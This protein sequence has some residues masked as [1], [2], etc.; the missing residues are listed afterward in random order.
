MK[1]IRIA[2]LLLIVSIPLGAT[3][4]AGEIFSFSPGVI[5]Q[6]MGN[7]GL[8][9]QASHAA[10]W[11][12]PALL[13]G[14]NLRGI[15]VM[16]SDYFEGLL[17]ENQASI[18]FSGGTALSINHLAIDQIK[19]TKLEDEDED[20]S[21]ENRP[22]VWKTVTNQDII[23]YGS[24][25]RPLRENL[26]VGISPKLAY[27]DLAEHSGW[28]LGADLGAYYQASRSLA[29]GMNLRDFFGTQIIWESGEHEIAMPNLDLE[30]GYSF[31]ALK[32]EIPVYLALRAQNFF[33]ERGDAA[34]LSSS[35]VSTDFH[36]GVMVQPISAMR[37]MMGY[38]V[39][40][41]TAG[42]GLG[43]RDLGI[44]YAFKSNAPDGLGHSQKISLTYSW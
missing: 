43:F 42:L 4:Y 2:I 40:S 38:D 3:K 27:R 34:N 39:E 7:T 8:T 30:A 6:A 11:W 44:N 26:Y 29:F 22:Y 15:E 33:E 21:N 35:I 28:G 18:R 37:I 13:A 20:L 31:S 17:T 32:Q 41:F 5:N 25:A 10:G 16:R 1:Y 9:M 24:F 14:D 36:A 12:N 23:L 19:L